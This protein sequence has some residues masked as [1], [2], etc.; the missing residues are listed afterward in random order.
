MFQAVFDTQT[1]TVKPALFQAA[2]GRFMDARVAELAPWLIGVA[3]GPWW[4]CG[5]FNGRR[6]CNGPRRQRG[7]VGHQSRLVTVRWMRYGF[8]VTRPSGI[9]RRLWRRLGRLRPSGCNLFRHR[10][11]LALIVCHYSPRMTVGDV[12]NNRRCMELINGM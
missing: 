2:A 1:L 10:G 6:L 4:Q 9:R 8:G 7:F 5:R 3:P 12:K 11:F